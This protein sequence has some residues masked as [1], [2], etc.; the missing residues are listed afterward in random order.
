LGISPEKL[1]TIFEPFKQLDESVT[2]IYNGAGLG[3]TI[4]KHFTEAL[5]GTI[6]VKSKVG[7]GSTFTICLP[8]EIPGQ[9]AQVLQQETQPEPLH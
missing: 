2:R 7:E 4:A 9:C 1:E 8:L 3:L 5:G 6:S